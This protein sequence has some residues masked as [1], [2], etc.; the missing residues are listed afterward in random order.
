MKLTIDI[1]EKLLARILRASAAATEE[2]A[3]LQALEEFTRLESSDALA[4][5][6]DDWDIFAD[7]EDEPETDIPARPG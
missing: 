1:P 2:D 3:V 7:D 5:P 4:E 6:K